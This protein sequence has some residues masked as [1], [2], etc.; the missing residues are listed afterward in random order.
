MNEEAIKKIGDAL[1]EF[2]PFKK[3]EIS[4]MVDSLCE[5][6]YCED[7][8]YNYLDVNPVVKLNLETYQL[9]EKLIVTEKEIPIE[10]LPFKIVD[11]DTFAAFVDRGDVVIGKYKTKTKHK[12]NYMDEIDIIN[13]AIKQC[14]QLLNNETIHLKGL[15]N[16]NMTRGTVSDE[17]I[18]NIKNQLIEE[19]SNLNNKKR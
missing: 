8:Y 13:G 2:C 6:R 17:Y 14:D 4:H 7:A 12:S 3:G 15:Y 9:E 19:L 18:I 5:G 10:L 16:I 1:C 11:G